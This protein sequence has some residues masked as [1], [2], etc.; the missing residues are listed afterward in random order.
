[1]A[2]SDSDGEFE[3]FL[4]DEDSASPEPTARKPR[5]GAY[6]SS[7]ASAV[8]AAAAALLASSKLTKKH[9]S[10]KKSKSSDKKRSKKAA[11]EDLS[12][13]EEAPPSYYAS[14]STK[15]GYDADPYAFDMTA[16]AF[17]LSE[18]E[19]IAKKKKKEQTVAVKKAPVKATLMSMED[20]I[21]EILKRTGSAQLQAS[22]EDK[23]EE[24]DG[25]SKVAE[26]NK[27][28]EE[29]VNDE[30]SA[31]N[32]NEGS[33]GKEMD[34]ENSGAGSDDE[35]SNFSDSLGVVSAD[36][37]VQLPPKQNPV[38]QSMRTRVSMSSL[39]SENFAVNREALDNDLETP[40]RY[41][42]QQLTF[43]RSDQGGDS[44]TEKDGYEDD[45]FGLD[46]TTEANTFP[47]PHAPAQT[48]I[49]ATV[50]ERK[51]SFV[52]QFDSM[53]VSSLL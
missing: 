17:P 33:Q 20:R 3:Q 1:M 52:S 39:D 37:E 49:E 30:G 26:V 36:F 43:S 13:S 18:E 25:N 21:T 40:S 11:R 24:E 7:S 10:K 35:H 27:E 12:E 28:R 44:A 5:P 47:P 32:T 48:S 16:S 6:S 22:D 29:M 46:Q 9:K 50:D 23:S 2:D 15:G 45:G 4:Q 42:Q 41:E 31:E 53:K 34:K 14:S 51:E 8:T 38:Q 19:N